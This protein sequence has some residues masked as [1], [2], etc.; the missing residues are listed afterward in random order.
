MS[1]RPTLTLTPNHRPTMSVL[2]PGATVTNGVLSIRPVQGRR[3]NLVECFRSE[4]RAIVIA[5]WRDVSP[6]ERYDVLILRL[7]RMTDDEIY[8]LAYDRVVQP[9]PVAVPIV[10]PPSFVVG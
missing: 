7:N 4:A 1:D 2:P 3:I 6:N 10:T 9:T 5:R 8:N